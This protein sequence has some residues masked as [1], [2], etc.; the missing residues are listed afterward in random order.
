M[1]IEVTSLQPFASV[2]VNELL[3]AATVN[4]PVPV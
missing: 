3:P 1:F 4:V 2:T